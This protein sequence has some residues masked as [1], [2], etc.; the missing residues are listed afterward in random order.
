MTELRGVLAAVLTPFR[1]GTEEVD[2]EALERQV[3]WTVAAG[4]DGVVVAGVETQE[5]QVL[6][7]AGRA[8][9]VRRTIEAI[10][11]RVPA[12]VGVTSPSL[13][14]SCSLVDSAVAAGADVVLA[15]A[16]LKPWGGVPTEAEVMSQFETLSAHAPVPVLVY[17]NPRFG[18]DLPAQTMVRL[19]ELDNV[20]YF[21]ETSRDIRKIGRLLV[22][23]DA[24][25]LARYFTT[26]EALLFTLQMGG[27][28]AMMPPPATLLAR[29]LIDAFDAGDL[30]RAVALQR[31]FT[32]FPD[33]W[34]R[35]GL[36][37]AMKAAMRAAGV[38][39]GD[40]VAPWQ[41]LSADEVQAIA[42]TLRE[43]MSHEM[44]GAAQ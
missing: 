23:I 8:E 30:A 6:D 15:I 43:E 28:G 9:L 19:A 11:G 42:S 33:D 26:M 44:T 4:C 22:D 20:Q 14:R 10:D 27:P 39:V 2:Y 38:T 40:P 17:N 16:A 25:G 3:D 13:R 35:L 37:P 34:M 7:D 31:I 29:R 41:A 21:K 32:H 1:D 24:A 5:Y 12:I 18:V 36:L